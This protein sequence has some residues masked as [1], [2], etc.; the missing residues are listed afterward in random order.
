[1]SQED[2]FRKLENMY[3]AAP[4]NAYYKP[5]LTVGN[6]TARLVLPVGSHLYHAAG[7]VHGS[8]YFKA[9]DDAAF[10]S[11][12]SLVK[13]VFVLTVTFN[14][15]LERP[16]SGGDLTAVGK[17]VSRSPRLIVAESF[18]YDDQEREI[19]RGSGTFM[20]SRVPLTGEIGYRD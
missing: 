19:A 20:K 5:R 2:H 17:V 14:L 7:A 1:M 6:G 4:C 12:N 18:L 16:V 10:F 8:A 15:Y 13:D 11:A 9:L 3:Q